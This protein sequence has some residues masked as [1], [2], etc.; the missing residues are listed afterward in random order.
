VRA[1]VGDDV[2]LSLTPELR[3]N[4]S[5]EGLFAAPGRDV[6]YGDEQAK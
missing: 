1:G 5:T 4:V 6:V 3:G 2:L